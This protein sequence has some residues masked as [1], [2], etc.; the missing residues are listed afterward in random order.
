MCHELWCRGRSL[1]SLAPSTLRRT[2]VVFLVSNKPMGRYN[3]IASYLTHHA[4]TI[5][6]SPPPHRTPDTLRTSELST[7]PLPAL[8]HYPLPHSKKKEENEKLRE[9]HG[10]ESHECVSEAA[11]PSA[12]SQGQP[13][14]VTFCASLRSPKILS[15]CFL[16]F[17]ASR[18]F[19]RGLPFLASAAGVPII[20]RR[21]IKF[22]RR[23]YLNVVIAINYFRR[24]PSLVRSLHS[25]CLRRIAF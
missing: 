15:A 20:E 5:S 8:P 6:P 11:S 3:T 2:S 12:G 25:L 7:M 24:E 14:D 22:R 4:A 23:H 13:R 21:R 18:F 9:S 16:D 1:A 19:P 17:S 10:A